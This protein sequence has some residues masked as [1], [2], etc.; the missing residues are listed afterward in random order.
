MMAL[1]NDVCHTNKECV[2][3]L[4]GLGRSARS[5]WRL[6]RFFRV[7]G[8]AVLCKTYPSRRHTI[9][10]LAEQVFSEIFRD[11]R[12]KQCEKVHFVTHSLG[13]VLLR[14]WFQVKGRSERIGRVVMLGVPNQG[15]EVTDFFRHW[16]L[17]Q[18]LT[19]PAGC[20]LGTG[21]GDVPKMLKTIN[22][23][24]G[25]IAG[26]RSA[27]PWFNFLFDG[28]HDGKVSVSSAR[29]AEMADF[30]TLDV[31]HT[32]MMWDKEVI[33]QAGHFIQKGHFLRVE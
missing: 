3:L 11:E 8:Y 9:E 1:M 17:Y 29:L 30:I 23:E 10:S 5:M 18:W 13:G 24:I 2:V 16:P 32:L 26:T 22:L 28:E 21:E 4:H 20:Q 12:I 15:S 6:A 33:Q 7:R 14:R 27:D 19:G 31:G 25:V